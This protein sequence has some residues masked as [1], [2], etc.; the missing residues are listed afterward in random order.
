MDY[1]KEKIKGYEEYSVDTNGMVYSKKGKP[2]KYSL[3]HS[4]YCIVNFMV[5]GK[6][7]GFAIHT[8]VARQFIT[9]NDINKTQVNHKDGDKTNNHIDNLEWV[10]PKENTQHAINV[11][12]F[13]N[14]GERNYNAKKVFGFDKKSGELKYSFPC[15]MD[16]GRYFSDGNETKARYI[17]DI[18][19]GIINGYNGKKSYRGCIWRYTI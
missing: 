4:G 15:V 8:L 16:A 1:R 18:I 5:N 13:D 14:S 6:R 17:Q 3:N 11:L 7:K 19:C 10:T 2:L 9:N 12:G